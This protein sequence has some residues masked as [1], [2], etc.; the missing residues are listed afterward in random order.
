LDQVQES[1]I[2]TPTKAAAVAHNDLVPD[3]SP[4]PPSKAITD[5]LRQRL[6]S[7]EFRPGQ[8]LPTNAQLAEHYQVARRTVNRALRILEAEG[9]VT[10][11]RSWGT[12]KAE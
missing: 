2:V 11:A 5:D 7:D 4:V 6:A 9:L 1:S 8:Q 12:F 10:I 3:R